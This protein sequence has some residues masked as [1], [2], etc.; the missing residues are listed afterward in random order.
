MLPMV[1][2]V[3]RRALFALGAFAIGTG[4]LGIVGI[5]HIKS[6]WWTVV[7]G[8]SLVIGGVGLI[9]RSRDPNLIGSGQPNEEL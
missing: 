2:K 1:D 9:R 3:L 6:V 8:L 5:M 4:V 7:V